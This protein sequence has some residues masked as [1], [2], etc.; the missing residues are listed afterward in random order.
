MAFFEFTLLKYLLRG[1]NL[2]NVQSDLR[3]SSHHKY[4]VG[5]NQYFAG[6]RLKRPLAVTIG[7]IKLKL[8]FPFRWTSTKTTH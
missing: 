4:I 2:L 5:Q 7:T 6:I 3:K 1:T 8:I